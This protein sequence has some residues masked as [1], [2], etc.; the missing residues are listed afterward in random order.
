[1]DY[2]DLGNSLP[3]KLNPV[4]R[5]KGH[6]GWCGPAAVSIVTGATTNEVSKVMQRRIFRAPGAVRRTGSYEVDCALRAYGLK[7]R[8]FSRPS[9]R[10][11]LA[12][13]LRE[14]KELRTAGTVFLINAGDHWQV[15]SGRRYCCG[16]VGK[17]VSIRDSRVKRRARVAEVFQVLREGKISLADEFRETAPEKETKKLKRKMYREW[18]KLKKQQDE[19]DFS[20]DDETWHFCWIDPGASWVFDPNDDSHYCHD[21]EDGIWAAKLYIEEYPNRETGKWSWQQD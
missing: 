16:V 13:W 7:L 17:I 12:G 11:T 10:P 5:P 8:F 15:V 2:R 1:M 3:I 9:P 20:V 14:N 21:I 6:N 18:S 4:N 19:F